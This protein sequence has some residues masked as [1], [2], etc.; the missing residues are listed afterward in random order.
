M[1]RG[2]KSCREGLKL[3]VKNGVESCIY[4]DEY[5]EGG[6]EYASV[7]KPTPPPINRGNKPSLYHSDNA[8]IDDESL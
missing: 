5:R 2:G 4:N 6:E 8:F 3:C 7:R 1:M